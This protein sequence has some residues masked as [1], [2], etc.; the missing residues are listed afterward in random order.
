MVLQ[1]YDTRNILHLFCNK[2]NVACGNLFSVMFFSA[3]LKF[4]FRRHFM[5]KGK[6]G[7][8][9]SEVKSSMRR[10]VHPMMECT[11]HMV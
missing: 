9:S 2:T 3:V 6:Q 1:I 11:E 8:K 4:V 10:F 7:F 5:K